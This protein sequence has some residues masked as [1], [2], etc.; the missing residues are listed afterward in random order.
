MTTAGD[1]LMNT[2]PP[3]PP[4]MEVLL[5]DRFEQQVQQTA[6]LGYGQRD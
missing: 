5:L 3:G 6:D 4:Q 1:G 2:P